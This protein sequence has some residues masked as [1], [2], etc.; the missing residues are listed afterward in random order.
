MCRARLVSMS[1]REAP[2]DHFTEEIIQSSF[3]AIGEEMF[4]ALQRSSMSPI[5][6]ETLDYAVGITDAVANLIAQG[7]GVVSFLGTLD[8]AVISVR[9]KFKTGN[10][11][12]GDIF[13]TNDPYSGGGTHLSDVTLVLP[14]FYDGEL[15]AFVANKAHWTE[16]GGK[17]PGSF[18]TDATEIYQEGLQLPTVKL[19]KEYQI[20]QSLLDLLAANVR[21]PD[22]TL[23]DLWAGIAAIR[24]G[25]R[26]LLELLQRYGK[27]AVLSAKDALL[28]YGESMSRTALQALPKGVFEA[29]DFIDSDGLGHGPFRVQVKVTITDDRF[30]I[31]Y[32]GS[33]RQVPGP[34]NTTRTGLESRARAI[35]RAVTTPNL[36][37]NGGMFRPLEVRCPEGTVFTAVRPAPTSI[38]WEAGGLAIDLVWKALA[39][40]VPERLPAGGFLSVCAT[41]LSGPH[42]ETGE[43]YLLVEP[44]LGGW[45]AGYNKDGERG[46]FCQSN[47]ETYN[48]PIE[49][50]EQRYGVRVERYQLHTEDG[51]A[52]AYRGGNG[53]LLDYLVLSGPS[54]VTGIYGRCQFRPWGAHGGYEG[55]K[56]AIR[57][58]RVSGQEECL[59]SAARVPLAAGD[60]VRL[61]TGTGGGWGDPA[62]RSR[63]QV[64][65]DLKNEYITSKQARLH[66]SFNPQVE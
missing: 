20:D 64:L 54:Y 52:G 19:M 46:Q 25:E 40:H 53:V 45:G 6:Y 17:A 31:D 14:V 35:F 47:G 56:N 65:D 18:T 41:I 58:L 5:I 4:I 28:D 48:I 51:G 7:N 57:I 22:R 39:T 49:I 59:A 12:P 3:I 38:Y 60:I 61:V 62:K 36:P 11:F 34:V 2:L 27:A 33:H 30:I 66:Y 29:E 10:I 42:P 44:L 50:T 26:R 43:L 16:M 24:I 1:Q 15:V 13:V 32:T 63:Q 37:T 55:S 21:L 9:K 23:G 8:A